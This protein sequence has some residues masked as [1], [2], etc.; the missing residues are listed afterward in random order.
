MQLGREEKDLIEKLAVPTATE[1]ARAKALILNELKTGTTQRLDHLVRLPTEAEGLT[2]QGTQTDELDLSDP[3]EDHTR[4][5]YLRL[6][7]AAAEAIGQ[8]SAAG[9]IIPAASAGH[10]ATGVRWDIKYRKGAQSG[11]HSVGSGRP[12]LENAAYRLVRP[13][14]PIWAM[15]T[16]FLLAGAGHL[17][18]PAKT[19]RWLEEALRAYRHGLYFASL[20]LLGAGSE[21]A[22]FHLAEQ[23]RNRSPKIER[24][25]DDP[26]VSAKTV[27]EAVAT[28]LRDDKDFRRYV[29]EISHFA[30]LL[31]RI[32]NYGIHPREEDS[33]LSEYF[34]ET[35]CGTLLLGSRDYLYRLAEIAGT[36]RDGGELRSS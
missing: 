16:D 4:V 21:G 14:A 34:D 26:R 31:R 25:L 27:Q 7:R 12:L 23:L 1:V 33:H 22:W 20:S 8:L 3:R 19:V 10:D 6:S 5:T 13:D 17:L 9:T 15:N 36:Y 11:K 30:S 28:F 35:K 18:L 32:R 24:L 2:G 29:D